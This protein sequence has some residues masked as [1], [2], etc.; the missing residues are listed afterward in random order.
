MSGYLYAIGLSLLSL[1]M[2]VVLLRRRRIREKYVGIWLALGSAVIVFAVF[3]GAA[4]WLARVLG[5][6]TPANLLFAA[7]IV[8]LLAVCVQLSVELSSTE[9]KVRTLT[10]EIALLRLHVDQAQDSTET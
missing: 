5:V 2:I 1:T 4:V 7:A 10:E 9:E 3:P 8:V 6:Q